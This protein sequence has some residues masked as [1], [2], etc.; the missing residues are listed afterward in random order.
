MLWV[1]RIIS[2]LMLVAAVVSLIY[3][4]LLYERRNELRKRGESL[5]E[6][7]YSVVKTLDANSGTEY[8]KR[9]SLNPVTGSEGQPLPGGVLGWAYYHDSEDPISKTFPKFDSYLEEIKKQ[10]S[11]VCTQR[12]NLAT[13]ISE[14]ATLFDIPNIEDE[15]LQDLTTYEAT[16]KNLA[17]GLNAIRKRDDAI[18][19][20]L[21]ETANK[22]GY[23]LDGAQISNP[24][25]YETSLINFAY[26]VT[27]M[28]ER[29]VIY[30]DTL[31]QAIQKIDAHQFEVNVQQLK[32]ENAYVS[33]ISALLND[34]TN[35]NETLR[36]YEKYKIEFL[37]TKDTLEKTIAALESTNENMATVE[38]KFANLEAE[39]A[40]LNQKYNKLIG[41]T[42][43]TQTTQ[44]V[45]LE[46]HV[47]DVNYDWN[48][49]IIDLGSDDHLPE[50]LEMTVAREQEY[51]CK[52][53]VS[54]VYK[55]HA[56]GEIL[57]KNKLGNIIEGDRVI[58]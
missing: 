1:N 5:A 35:I 49:V 37:E 22:I 48:Y 41:D 15:K 17:D 36:D 11:D 54:K 56:V 16:R 19:A 30:A 52:I 40:S 26:H 31:A 6:T 8:N 57:Q 29:V 58:F 55:N 7:V 9:I 45:N 50:N 28:K 3:S 47:I 43:L 14:T 38:N 33:E 39:Y 2:I 42:S 44:L 18:I 46:G 12:D 20:K 32:D 21:V 51:I 4:Y 24:Q 34:F 23:P 13:A 53:V 25:T 27:K 10:A